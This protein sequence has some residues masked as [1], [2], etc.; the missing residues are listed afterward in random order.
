MLLS[1]EL[2]FA[3]FVI[4]LFLTDLTFRKFTL[5]FLTNTHTHTHTHTQYHF[6]MI[7]LAG[8]DFIKKYLNRHHSQLILI[9]TFLIAIVTIVT[10]I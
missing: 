1:V 9:L 6:I 3:K 4:L 5:L 2:K 8:K 10:C 7:F